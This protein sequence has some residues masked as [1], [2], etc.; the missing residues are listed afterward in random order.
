[1]LKVCHP[2]CLLGSVLASHNHAEN[3][4]SWTSNA[5]NMVQLIKNV[6]TVGVIA[7]VVLNT[8]PIQHSVS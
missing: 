6:I 5:T 2:Q 8:K 7:I 4:V 3:F 1:M